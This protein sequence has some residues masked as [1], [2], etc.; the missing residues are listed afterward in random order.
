[1]PTRDCTA[2]IDAFP[3]LDVAEGPRSAAEC[4]VIG[5]HSQHAGLTSDGDVVRWTDRT[6][7]ARR[8]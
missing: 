3:G 4:S 8:G 7:G 1:M 6:E 2:W 5:P